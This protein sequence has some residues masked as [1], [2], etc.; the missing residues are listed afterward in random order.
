MEIFFTE[1]CTLAFL[2]LGTQSLVKQ[3]HGVCFTG[4]LTLKKALIAIRF[5]LPLI[6]KIVHN[7][8]LKYG[9]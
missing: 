4:L 1:C 7:N 2:L 8:Y 5:F 9:S 3:N 6:K